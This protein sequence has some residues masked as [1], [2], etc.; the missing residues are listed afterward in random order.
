MHRLL[1][2]AVAAV[3][4]LVA[5]GP[6]DAAAVSLTD[7]GT[8]YTLEVSNIVGNTADVT[9]TADTSGFVQNPSK[10]V[11]F[12]QAVNWSL[13]S[14]ATILSATL[15]AAPGSEL[16]WQTA[17]GNLN[18]GACN[19]NPTSP[20]V[21]SQ[22]APSVTEA[23]LGGTLVWEYS[24]TFGGVIDPDLLGAHIGAKY[25]NAA[26]SVNGILTSLEVPIPEPRA[27]LAFGCGL[28]VVAAAIR[29]R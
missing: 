26:G 12:I 2:C 15:D 4:S 10:L 29:R 22:D 9:F 20:K 16:L 14:G 21:C 6:R 25:N 7:K 27:A 23:V 11:G 24:I 19:F 5:V 1:L 13:G 3:C 18:N 17:F 28:L 8:V